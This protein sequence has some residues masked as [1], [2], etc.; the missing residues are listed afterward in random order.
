[1][2]RS[3]KLKLNRRNIEKVAEEATLSAIRSGNLK[4][5]CPN[6]GKEVTVS[7]TPVT[8]ECGQVIQFSLGN[9]VW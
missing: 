5:N 3:V 1:M 2:S 6:C 4:C 8:C 9:T 7:E